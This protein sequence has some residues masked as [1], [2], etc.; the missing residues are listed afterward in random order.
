MYGKSE[1]FAQKI[2]DYFITRE[3][4]LIKFVFNT[5]KNPVVYIPTAEQFLPVVIRPDDI[6]TKDN[7]SSFY[8]FEPDEKSIIEKLIPTSLKIN[9]FRVLLESSAS[10]QGARMTA[11]DKATE[12]AEELIGELR[13]TY[14]KVRQTSITNEL[15]EIVSGSNALS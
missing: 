3:Y 9:F 5:F 4:D 6:K 12:N 8:I 14:N 10:E 11:M 15:L 7:K 2:L 1:I 13:L